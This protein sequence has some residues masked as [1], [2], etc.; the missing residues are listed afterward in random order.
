M[1]NIDFHKWTI[2]LG[3]FFTIS[4]GIICVLEQIN[5]Q[6]MH[7]EF[8]ILPNILI[9]IF[10]LGLAIFFRLALKIWRVQIAKKVDFTKLA[11]LGILEISF[12]LF[13]FYQWSLLEISNPIKQTEIEKLIMPNVHFALSISKYTR[14]TYKDLL[15]SLFLEF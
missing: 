7:F 15:T 5:P 14:D 2:Y 1:K 6:R 13:L 4:F 8:G 9:L 12:P 3:T 11:L 10:F